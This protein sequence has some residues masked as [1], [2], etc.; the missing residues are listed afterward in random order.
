MHMVVVEL[1]RLVQLYS[2]S[3]EDKCVILGKL[4]ENYESTKMQLAIA[5]RRLEMLDAH[6]SLSSDVE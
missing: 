2:S 3:W 4:H 1:V 5:V 6:V